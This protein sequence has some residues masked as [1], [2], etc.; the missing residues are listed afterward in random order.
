MTLHPDWKAAG[1]AL[2]VPS[3]L[4]GDDFG[5][6][7]EWG[8]PLLCR[9]MPSQNCPTSSDEY[10]YISMRGRG[11]RPLLLLSDGTPMRIVDQFGIT[12]VS[13]RL[14]EAANCPFSSD[15]STKQGPLLSR[16]IRL[17]CRFGSRRR[18]GLFVGRC[19][20][21]A[22]GYLPDDSV[23]SRSYSLTAF[24]TSGSGSSLAISS[25]RATMGCWSC[26]FFAIATARRT[27]NSLSKGTSSVLS[28]A[29]S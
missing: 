21:L 3:V 4:V 29:L 17:S 22:D 16:V 9:L 23:A 6:S 25:H 18:T 27:H 14:D 8:N 26:P 12:A 24:R 11:E 28:W 15:H 13:F 10:R 20:R 5:Y 2:R 1:L 7:R 19:S